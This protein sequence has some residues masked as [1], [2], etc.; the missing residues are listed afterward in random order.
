MHIVKPLPIKVN[1]ENPFENDKFDRR[2]FADV[3]LK[4]IQNSEPP[5][6]ICIDSPW[7]TGKTTFI[8]M[9]STVLEQNKFP[10]IVFN[11]WENDFDEDP[12]ISLIA[13]FSTLINSD[14]SSLLQEAY[15]KTKKYS[16]ALIKNSLPVILKLATA[17]VLDINQYTEEQLS[18][19]VEN[20]VKRKLE[21]YEKSKTTVNNFKTQLKAYINKV[22]GENGVPLIFI[23]DELDRCKP[24]FAINLLERIKHLF[25][26]DNIIFIFAIDKTQISYS[27]QKVYGLNPN[28]DGYLKRFF[29]LEVK[30]SNKNFSEFIDNALENL[31]THD[32]LKAKTQLPVKKGDI[33][34]LIELYTNLFSLTL[35]DIERLITKATFVIKIIPPHEVSD[36]TSVLFLLS[37][38]SNNPQLYLDFT[39][40]ITNAK[41][42][43]DYIVNLP[44]Y[45]TF[46]E[47]RLGILTISS[48]H[49]SNTE[50]DYND[51]LYATRQ[52][53]TNLMNYF[54]K[55]NHNMLL[56]FLEGSRGYS[57][58]SRSSRTQRI[59]SKIELLSNFTTD[60]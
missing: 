56:S 9:F 11:A 52:K 18:D 42:I 24:T 4:I 20:S 14:G 27:I 32:Y 15:E 12:L 51:F 3:L 31:G 35:R 36:F 23:I 60:L 5:Y 19:L 22:N 57:T 28:T 16:I 7:G 50:K 13:K 55:E 59:S 54:E 46:K 43:H 41:A 25:D 39:K 29:D 21:E 49:S 53:D 2:I 40:G 48:I 47:N 1:K 10:Y 38:K 33:I 44:S 17:G 58:D 30:L 8:E 26:I 6:T 34:E 45:N 37:L